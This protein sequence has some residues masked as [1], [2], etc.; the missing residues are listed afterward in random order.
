MTVGNP[1][2]ASLDGPRA[3]LE[4]ARHHLEA[5]HDSIR[6]YTETDTH[7]FIHEI[8]PET[9]DQIVRIRILRE[10]DNPGW[11]LI[12]GDFAHNLRS[13]LDHLVWQLVILSGNEPSRA[14]QFPIAHCPADYWLSK[15]RKASM[16][17]RMLKGVAAPHRA[18]IDFVQPYMGE[19]PKETT[20]AHLHWLSNVDKHQVIHGGIVRVVE[21]TEELF[22]YRVSGAGGFA[23]MSVETGPLEDG[24][25]VARINMWATKPDAQVEMDAS[26]PV[27]IGFGE[28]GFPNY[29][30]TP[31]FNWITGYILNFGPVFRGQ[32]HPELPLDEAE[33]PRPP[34]SFAST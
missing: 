4:R 14:N 8:D 27:Y 18:M 26:F 6:A 15:G 24:A 23:D 22:D 11:G 1:L 30:F 29:T 5:L 21:P 3:K 13:A 2:R 32:R 20:L 28:R 31:L 7:N 19:D 9:G 16:R 33:W 12:I 34:D 10:P 25:E 17:D